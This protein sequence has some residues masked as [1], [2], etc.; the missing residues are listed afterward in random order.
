[1]DLWMFNLGL[2]R[3]GFSL[4][5]RAFDDRLITA[6]TARPIYSRSRKLAGLRGARNP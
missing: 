5:R 3:V 1:M 4:P 6:A 2:N